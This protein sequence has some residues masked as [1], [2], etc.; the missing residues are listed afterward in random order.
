MSE[1][2]IDLN[3]SFWTGLLAP[4]GTPAPIIKRIQ[5]EMVKIIAM[6]DIKKRL[7]SLYVV[8]ASSTPEEMSKLINSEI[9]LWRQV[10]LENNIKAEQ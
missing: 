9:S 2:G 6:P 8:P 3:V 10:A 4:S 1:L 7:A 5:E